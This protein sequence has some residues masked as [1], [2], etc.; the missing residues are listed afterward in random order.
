MIF[1]LP[2][3][4]KSHQDKDKMTTQT[5]KISSVLIHAGGALFALAYILAKYKNPEVFS[6]LDGAMISYV[7]WI[8]L[9]KRL[10]KDA[11]KGE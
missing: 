1:R 5:S 3:K 9:R 10:K 4:N 11:P 6:I 2:R 8:I 7:V